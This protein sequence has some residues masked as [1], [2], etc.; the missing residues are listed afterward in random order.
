MSEL[1]APSFAV[2]VSVTLLPELTV[3]DETLSTEVH[4]LI[5]PGVTVTVGIVVVTATPPI[6]A[7]RVVAVPAK[8][9]VRVAV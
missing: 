1:P 3:A 9:P 7:L 2:R 6:V 4:E 5:V 8:I